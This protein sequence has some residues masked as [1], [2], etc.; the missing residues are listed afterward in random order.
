M[1][2]E[3]VVIG[4]SW[5]GIRALTTVLGSLSPTFRP[6]IAVAQHRGADGPSG[7]LADVL[8]SRTRLPVH[9]AID[10]E[11]IVPGHVYV[12]PA[13]YHLL[14]ERGT[15]ALSTDAPE[16][17]SRPSINVLFESAADAYGPEVVGVIL[18]GVGDDGAAGLARIRHRGGVGLV[19]DPETAERRQMPEAAL[20]AGGAQRVL[21]L[22]EIAPFLAAVC[23]TVLG[24]GKAAT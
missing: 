12:A 20:A 9:E 17:Y 14:V 16:R 23:G 13:D 21:P 8:G 1:G 24:T 4:A 19:Q 6:A 18:T 11:P 5:G 10:K 2:H 15:L 3:L 22:E 7:G